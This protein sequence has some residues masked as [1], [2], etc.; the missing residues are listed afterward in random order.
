MK[1]PI[2]LVGHGINVVR[3]TAPPH[4]SFRMHNAPMTLIL[5]MGLHKDSEANKAEGF[6]MEIR[7]CAGQQTGES[8]S[9][10]NEP[11][12]FLPKRDWGNA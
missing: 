7:R 9:E 4:A 1:Q 11:S 12:G 6:A 10:S 2:Q 5:A 8:L 3:G